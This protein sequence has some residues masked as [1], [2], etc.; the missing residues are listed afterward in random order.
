MKLCGKSRGDGNVDATGC[1]G[2]ME[3]MVVYVGVV[4]CLECVRVTFVAVQ[5]LQHDHMVSVQEA[6]QE[7]VVP[8]DLGRTGCGL[9]K[10]CCQIPSTNLE[11]TI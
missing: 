9:A 3:G 7:L 4:S 2:W 11:F 10:K 1:G 6:L 8:V 5:L